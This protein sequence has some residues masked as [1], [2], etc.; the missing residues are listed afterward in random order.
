MV[1]PTSGFP[2]SA[3]SSLRVASG[4]LVSA[5]AT[6]ISL[7]LVAG[8]TESTVALSLGTPAPFNWPSKYCSP[9]GRRELVLDRHPQRELRIALLERFVL[10]GVDLVLGLDVEAVGR[11]YVGLGR[12]FQ[13]IQTRVVPVIPDVQ[14]GQVLIGRRAALRGQRALPS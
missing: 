5:S 11:E 10:L 13:F 7:E 12:G 2:T 1:P 6:T 4:V 14:F 8:F 3:S 9:V